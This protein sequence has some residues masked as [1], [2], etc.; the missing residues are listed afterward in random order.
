MCIVIAIAFWPRGLDLDL[1]RTEVFI[2]VI[3]GIIQVGIF[4]G[5]EVR[6][7]LLW[8]SQDTLEHTQEG[9]LDRYP[10]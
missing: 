5:L 4:Q 8:G 7:D 3:E 10:F 6:D 1:N 9:G 2:G